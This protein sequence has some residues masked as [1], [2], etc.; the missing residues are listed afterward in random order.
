MPCPSHKPYKPMRIIRD[1]L[2]PL[3]WLNPWS[4]ARDLHQTACALKVL[5]DL[6]DRLIQ[7]QDARIAEL[8]AGPS[9]RTP[10]PS[11]KEPTYERVRPVPAPRPHA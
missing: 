8:E 2:P 1:S 4:V 6:D 7:Q 11:R 9:C 3:W 10:S 5:T